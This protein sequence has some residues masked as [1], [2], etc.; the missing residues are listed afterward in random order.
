MV[1]FD[2]RKFFDSVPHDLVVR[3]VAGLRLPAWVLLYV[4]RWLAAPVIMPDGGAR[5][6]DRGTPQG[7]AVSPVLAN[8]FLHW[9]FDA[10]MVR[11]FPD[12]PFERYA[13]DGLVHCKSQARARQVLAALEQRMTEVGLELHPDKTR[14]IY[15]KD[16]RRRKPWDGPVSFGFLGYAFRPRDTMGKNGRFTGFD[17]AVSPKAVKRMNAVVSLWR[18]HR[19][20]G[21][22]W[23]QLAGWIGPVIR[24]WM[25]YYGRF[26]HSVLDPLLAR[27]NHHVQKWIKRK[28]RR[29]RPYRAMKRAWNRITTQTPGLLPHWRWVTGAWY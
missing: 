12:C 27:I 17:L 25:A 10:W 5:P 24:G 7:S 9:A 3:A 20:T 26:R 28:Y 2:I 13:D 21:L 22:T 14:I 8:L 23:E 1:E 15:C 29:L 19:L 18:L 11:E 16:S 6:R 4:T